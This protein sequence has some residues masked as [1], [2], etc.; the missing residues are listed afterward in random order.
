MKNIGILIVFLISF[1][2]SI[3]VSSESIIKPKILIPVLKYSFC[4]PY[5]SGGKIG[6]V[7]NNWALELW[8]K[9]NKLSGNLTSI[10]ARFHQGP[11][12]HKYI[13]R[14]AGPRR[15]GPPETA[16][17]SMVELSDISVNIKRLE[18]F[19]NGMGKIILT[20]TAFSSLQSTYQITGGVELSC[21]GPLP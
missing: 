4:T 1:G 18:T 13:G 6:L 15:P 3:P 2:I 9:N 21:I 11:N 12:M 5:Q 16:E 7:G 10:D 19:G 8:F 17:Y 20:T 14:S